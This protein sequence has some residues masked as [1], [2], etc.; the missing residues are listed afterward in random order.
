MCFV[1]EL[2]HK[3]NKLESTALSFHAFQFYRFL[4]EHLVEGWEGIFSTWIWVCN[5]VWTKLVDCIEFLF[6]IRIEFVLIYSPSNSSFSSRLA[7]RLSRRSCLSISWL[8]RFCSFASSD[9]QHSMLYFLLSS[10]LNVHQTWFM[11]S[12]CYQ[13][14]NF[15]S[16]WEMIFTRVDVVKNVKI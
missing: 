7:S 16:L 2:I 6:Y 1:A 9:K 13:N 14:D 10:F 15:F 11:F 3:R 5:E 12:F 4:T 8:M